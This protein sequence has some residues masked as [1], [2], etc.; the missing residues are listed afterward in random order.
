[1]FEIIKNGAI[2]RGYAGDC[3]FDYQEPVEGHKG[4]FCGGERP[5]KTIESAVLIYCWRKGWV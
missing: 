2:P 3:S 5:S 4:F 1:M